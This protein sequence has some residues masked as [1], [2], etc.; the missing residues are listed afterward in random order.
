MHYL[1][2]NTNLTI[3]EKIHE[4]PTSLIFPISGRRSHYSYSIEVEYIVLRIDQII[5]WYLFGYHILYGLISKVRA[6]IF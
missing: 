2:R 5:K 6:Y 4:E 3:S 1:S